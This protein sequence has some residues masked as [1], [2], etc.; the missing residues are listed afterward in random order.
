MKWE[1]L[2]AILLIASLFN[3][4]IELRQLK[5]KTL[6]KYYQQ[7]W[8]KNIPQWNFHNYFWLWKQ[9]DPHI[10]WWKTTVTAFIFQD[11]AIALPVTN[12][13]MCH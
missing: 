6:N 5:Y 7:H 12:I 10:I 4:S 11:R 2:I 3:K 13:A 9:S 8:D 1:E